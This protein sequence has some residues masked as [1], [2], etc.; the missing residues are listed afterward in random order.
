MRLFRLLLLDLIV[1]GT[2]GIL[3]FTDIGRTVFN[4]VLIYFLFGL[5]DAPVIHHFWIR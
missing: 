3:L 4:Y 2:A 1:F 5:M